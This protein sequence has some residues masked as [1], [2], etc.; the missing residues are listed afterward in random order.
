MRQISY[1][2]A[3]NE[4]LHQE[5]VRD[6]SIVVYGLGAHDHKKV[7]GTTSRLLEKFGDDRCFDMPLSEWAMTGFGIGAAVGGLRPIHIHIRVDFLLLAMDQLVNMASSYHYTSGSRVPFVIRAIIGRGWGQGCHH[8]KSLHS[9]FAHIPG[10]KVIA[11][12]TPYDVKGLLISAIRD[13]NPVICLEHRWLYWGEGYV[14]EDSYTVPIGEPNVVQSGNDITIIATSWLVVEALKAAEI[15]AQRDISVE[16]VDV[17]TL[18]PYNNSVAMQS[19]RKTGHCIVADNDWTFCGFGAEI[20]A[21]ISESC[22]DY[23][24][25]PVQR[26]GWAHTPCP[27]VRCLENEFYPNTIDIIRMA[28]CKLGMPSTDLSEEDFYNHERKFKGPF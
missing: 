22:F 5:M 23:L 10:L 26:I 12:V 6:I 20:A 7:F 18:S 21:Q 28:E 8:S 4:A 11:P 13:D 16:V 2:N 17:R 15:L 3:I 9:C 24:E 19:V 27:T 1:A 25:S 14:P